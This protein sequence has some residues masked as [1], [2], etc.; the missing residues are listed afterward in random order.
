MSLSK[1]QKLTF[2]AEARITQTVIILEENLSIEEISEGIASGTYV[3]T[4]D[5]DDF[6]GKEEYVCRVNDDHTLDRVARIKKQEAEGDIALY[7]G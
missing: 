2:V 5:Y 1:P 3:T 7:R 4:I 6:N